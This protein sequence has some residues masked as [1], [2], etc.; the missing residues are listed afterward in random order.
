MFIYRNPGAKWW[1]GKDKVETLLGKARIGFA[2]ALYAIERIFTN[3]IGMTI[4]VNYHVHL[5]HTSDLIVDVYTKQA[6]LRD[7]VPVSEVF[8]GSL[9]IVLARLSA[10]GV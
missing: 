1:I 9:I 4:I 8:F 5:G 7:I 10:H 2:Q 3:H 6:S